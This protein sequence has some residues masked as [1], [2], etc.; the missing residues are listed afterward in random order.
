M[1]TEEG[2]H[3]WNRNFKDFLQDRNIDEELSEEK[4]GTKIDL[5]LKEAIHGDLSY[6]S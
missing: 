2:Y 6:L 5:A 1:A 3:Q 4:L